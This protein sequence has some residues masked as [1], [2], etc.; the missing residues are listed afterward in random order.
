M[1][2]LTRKG[3]IKKC[4]TMWSLCVRERDKKC[5][6][7]GNTVNGLEAHHGI[8]ARGK[9]VGEHWFMLLNGF[10]LDFPCHM[11]VHSRIGD[12]SLLEKWFALVD[13]MVTKE[14]QEEIIH[15]RHKVMK[16]TIEDLEGIYENLAKEYD[17]IKG[18]R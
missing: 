17:R 7:C 15:A 13:R 1:R 14:Q 16:Y 4:L 9:G 6:L 11:L 8:A 2:K 10:S 3:A 12:K 18:E 5:V